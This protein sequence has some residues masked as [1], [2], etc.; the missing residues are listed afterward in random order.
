M[1]SFK[2][3]AQHRCGRRGKSSAAHA[4]SKEMQHTCSQSPQLL[5]GVLSRAG[6][7]ARDGGASLTG[8]EAGGTTVL[9]PSAPMGTLREELLPLLPF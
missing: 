7:D 2:Q 9:T 8:G 6:G 1:F 4:H 5:R 3:T